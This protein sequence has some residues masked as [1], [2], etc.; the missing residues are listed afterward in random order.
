MS[1]VTSVVR[2]PGQPD[3]VLS[4]GRRAAQRLSWKSFGTSIHGLTIERGFGGDS[5]KFTI[6]LRVMEVTSESS[7]WCD[8]HLAG[9][10]FGAGPVVKRRAK[11]FLDQFV[12]V[13]A[14]EIEAGN[15]RMLNGEPRSSQGPSDSGPSQVSSADANS[16]NKRASIVEAR[17]EWR[18]PATPVLQ[19][20]SSDW[21][22][23]LKTKF[24]PLSRALLV[25]YHFSIEDYDQVRALKTDNWSTG[26]REL[27]R[28]L[29]TVAGLAE[30]RKNAPGASDAP[31]LKKSGSTTYMAVFEALEN[32]HAGRDI[33]EAILVL[34][35][36]CH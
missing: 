9:R 7:H 28:A 16:N 1:S 5:F 23:H 10:T 36:D 20:G 24:G 21:L 14:K 8:V 17:P 11:R 18:R 35:Q 32:G 29:Q 2:V 30:S 26:S 31:T 15:D 33:V 6:D 12:L 19:P 13:L 4:A 3:A 27:D 22:V 34:V 25:A